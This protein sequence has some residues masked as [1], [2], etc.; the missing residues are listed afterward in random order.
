MVLLPC[1]GGEMAEQEKRRHVRIK[2]ERQ[3]KLEFLTEV[4]DKCQVNDISL[5]GMFV[6]GEFPKDIDD[7][8]YVNITQ[9]SQDT[10]LKLQ[11][12][13]RVVRQSDE[14]I[15][16]EFTSMS[17]ESLLSLEMILLFQEREKSSSIEM[18]LPESLPFEIRQETSSAPDKYNFLLDRS[19]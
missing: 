17:F 13:A 4:Y 3:V 9:T 6:I 1:K 7:K 15:A 18:K 19:E 5:G 11:A 16:I 10:C 8:C 12:L 2:I 14:G